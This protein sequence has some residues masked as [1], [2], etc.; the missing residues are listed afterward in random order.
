[1]CGLS[2]YLVSDYETITQDLRWIKFIYNGAP[3]IGL[4]LGDDTRPGTSNLMVAT[5]NGFRTFK[6]DGMI[7]VKDITTLGDYS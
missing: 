4:D 5:T 1:M 6:K 7:G 3:R 2:S